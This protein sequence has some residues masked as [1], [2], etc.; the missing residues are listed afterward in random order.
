MRQPKVCDHCGGRFGMVTYR[1]RGSKFCKRKCKD[2]YRA[3]PAG[4]QAA[5]IHAAARAFSL[6]VASCF[7]RKGTQLR[8][9]RTDLGERDRHEPD[10]TAERCRA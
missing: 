10:T 2:V 6:I 5:Y 7:P 1:W 9:V 4:M 3:K 8:L